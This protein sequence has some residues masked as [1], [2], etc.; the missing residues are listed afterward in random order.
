M[1]LYNVYDRTEY[2]D[3]VTKFVADDTWPSVPAG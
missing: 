3:R 1:A 2:V